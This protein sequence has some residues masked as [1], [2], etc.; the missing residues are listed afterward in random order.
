MSL[1][2]T[3]SN[4]VLNKILN[5]LKSRS[6]E[7]KYKAANDLKEHVISVSREISGE[8]FT[9]FINDVNRRIFA[10]I[11]SN[12]NDEKIGGIL[13]IDS[14]IDFDGEENTT[15]ITRFANYLRFVLPGNDLQTMVLASKALGRLALSGGTL[16]PEFVEFEVKRA[17]EW[18]QGDRHESKRYAA[19]LVLK[20]LAQNA[21]ILIYSYVTQ[22]LNLIW[23]VLKDPKVVIREGAANALSVCL[24]LIQQRENNK[25][26]ELYKS[27]LDEA[28][29]G[30]KFG[31]SDTVHGCLLVIRELLLHT[32]NFMN[33]YYEDITDI[34][35][36]N[37]D[38]KDNLIRRTVI[39]LMS[40]LASFDPQTFVDNYLKNCMD[41]LLNQLKKDRDRSIA[42]TSIGK[43]A[44]AV[45]SNIGPYLDSIT[46]NIR[47]VLT[48]KSRSRLG[49][50]V[51]IFQCISMLATAVGQALTKHMHELLDI[52]LAQ[53]LSEALIQALSDLAH[54]IPPLL[55]AIQDRLLNVLSIILS[56][57]PYHHPNSLKQNNL[58][59]SQIQLQTTDGHDTD[60]IILALKTLGTFNFSGHMLNEFVREYIVRY[61]EDDNAEVRKS[62]AITCCH[63]LV[64]DPV[65]YQ[66]SNNSMLIVGEVLEKL[67]TVGITDSDPQIRKTV[68][69]SLDER[70]DH[71]LAQAENIRTLFLALNDEVFEIREV[72]I[73][74]IGR[75]IVHN[76]AYIMPSLRK[77]LIQLLSEIEYSGV[78]RN[79][80]E[81]ARLLS[82]LIKNSR[83]LI[84]P[85]VEPLLKVL[86]PK[87]KD[88]SP[89]VASESLKAIGELALIGEEMIPYLD[90]LFPMIIETLQ[91]QSNMTKRE[92]ALKT[93]GQLASNTGYIIEPYI[94]YPNLLNILIGI[95]KTEQNM[96]IRRQTLKVMGILGALDPYK[97]KMALRNP[98]ENISNVNNETPE[99]NLPLGLNP[100][101]E[102]YYPTVAI[103]ALMR[104]LRDPS[105]NV[106]HTAVVQAIIYIFKTLG[107]KCV[108]FLPQIMP[109]FLNMMRVCQVGNLE[110]YFQQLGILVTVVKQHIRNYL[111]E[112]YQL[113][114]EFWNFNSNI[115]LTIISLMESIAVALNCEFKAYLPQLLPQLLQIFETDTSE[116]RQLTIKVLKAFIVFGS[117]LEE[118]LHLVIPVIIKLFERID[119][120]LD[121]RREAIQTIG[122]LCKNVNF[123]DHA[124]R[125][126][127]PLVRVLPN[128]ELR[129]VAMDTLIKLVL[130]LNSDYAIF[131]P[132]VNKILIKNHIQHAE[133]DSLVTKL[134]KN[135]PLQRISDNGEDSMEF[136]VDDNLTAEIANKKLP[137]NQ[138]HL[139]KAWEASQ[140]S[141]KEDWMEWLRRLSVELLKESPSPA[142]RA[143]A[144]LASVYYPLSR[145]LFNAGF[146][147]C[148]G[149]LY[150]QFQDELV[151]SLETAL[152]SPNIPPELIQTLLN[153]AEFMEHDDKALPI[154]IKTLG[155]FA[156][157]CHTYAKALH[158]KEL[159]FI[160]EPKP[161]NIEALISINNQLQQPDSAIGIL[162]YAQENHDI[163][164]KESWYEKLQRWEDALAA[165][166]RKQE[167]DPL[168]FEATIG[169][170][171]CLHALGEW[172]A[173]SQLVKEK[174]NV[175]SDK[176]KIMA[177]LAA[178][179]AWGLSDYELMEEYI[180]AMKPDSPDGSFFR[181]ILTVNSNLFPQ[182]EQYI[183]KTRDLLDTELTALVGESYN[184]AY[185][186]VV[187]IQMLAELEEII[188][189]KKLFDQPD[190]QAIIR[191]TWMKRLKGCQKNIDIWHR[192][193]RIQALVI[194]PKENMEMWIKFANL[195]RKGGRLNTALKTL[196]TLSNNNSLD[197]NPMS[198]PPP[199]VYAYL[200]YL[201]ATPENRSHAFQ[202]MKIFTQNLVD[203]LEN[204]PYN[205]IPY[206]MESNNNLNGYQN[207]VK[208]KKLIARCYL[209]L[210]E[211][212]KAQT[213]E[214]T[215]E[216][217]P[218][219]LN[220]LHSAT[221][222]DSE[223]YKA[224]HSWA[225]TNFEVINYYEKASD[226]NVSAKDL[227]EYVKPSIFGFFKS[228][229]LSK[230]NSLQD[231]LRLITLWFKYGY[232]VEVNAAVSEGLNRVSID[233]WL[234]VIPQLIARI[235]TNHSHV[236]SLLQQLLTDVGKEHPQALIYSLT[237]ASKSPNIERQ[238]A[239]NAIMEK[240]MIHSATLV[241]QA[242]LV[243]Q[244]L[245]RVAILWHEMWHEGLEEA[246]RLYFGNH[247]IEGMFATLQPL[248]QMLEKGPET[249]REI[250]FNQGFGRDLSEALD[251]CR[252]YSKTKDIN[253]LNQAWDLYYNVFRKINKQLPQLTTL[254]L[255]YV[256]PKLLNARDLELAV[257]GQ[258]RS[259]EPIIR[260]QSFVPTLNIITSKQRP[261]RLSIKGSDGKE[262][263]YLLKGH[264]DLRQDERVM[265]LFGLINTLLADDPE[266][267]TRHM[268]IQRYPVIP[269]SPNSGLIGWVPHCDTL[270]AL[271]RDYRESK[272]TLLNI[273]HRLM[274]QMAPDYDNLTLLQKV[275]VFEYAADNTTG[276]DL[277][278]VLWIKSRNSEAWLDR[279]TN[280]TR[281]L[282]VMSMVGYIL[283]LGD[284]HPSNLM[285]DRFTGKVVHIDFGDCFEVAMHREKFPE[286]IPFR[287]TR[288]L[289]NAM[290]VS[291]I[292]EAFVYDPLINWRLITNPSPK[293]DNK[294]AQNKRSDDDNRNYNGN[295]KQRNENEILNN[296]EAD[297]VEYLNPRAVQIIN[298]IQNK[299]TGRDFKPN[300]VLDVRSQ[301]YKLIEQ[302]TSVENLCQCYIGW[303]A[304]W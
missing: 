264:E 84:K 96:D 47:E 193:L 89:G 254:E 156:A 206:H 109:A 3:P 302:A 41:Y 296:E 46:L 201:W 251:W 185:S 121:L 30:L 184:R 183:N 48:Q 252:K 298:R 191:K 283:G 134:L 16:T 256:S 159:E 85:Y 147:S 99:D 169:K 71:H 106:H 93:L 217:I 266:T 8:N 195:C 269:L 247:N 154:D 291:G 199:V 234:Q 213:D 171:R 14:L 119:A 126:I 155:G 230:S 146:V 52:M 158:Y 64:N 10:L 209:R 38:S 11:Q 176:Q 239:A 144:S 244:E 258:Y 197:G 278:K 276:Q 282:A 240:M 143:C 192:I 181:A 285:L 220:S 24:V 75:L 36:K 257:P 261:R 74:I 162:T 73:T 25:N 140:R 208:L 111:T 59:Q 232:N 29:K 108:S 189:Y 102:E 113:I 87:C 219:I 216:M 90:D 95:L 207:N 1:S 112:I 284:R 218:E 164:L 31:S 33:G 17:L 77:T 281:S 125:I 287:L 229:A 175:F 168:S 267:F 272:K 286:R 78:S 196:L 18:L 120:P 182:A 222:Y 161:S 271:I 58:I 188:S 136:N 13:A 174:W 165:Y 172:E 32:G 212:Q 275:E 205:E 259:G 250:S 20:E 57:Q 214:L 190:R 23:V 15:K 274:L 4:E 82:H 260:I 187:R 202:I 28:Q 103:N 148:W 141:T 153:L 231:T 170:M 304:F 62:A 149:E 117:N 92:V 7:T 43:I 177:P 139:K 225:L 72:T 152:T 63:L 6:E 279:R 21:P 39:S 210:G 137:V 293:V 303:C 301:V 50:E 79:K 294:Q 55:P 94:K 223:W 91:D 300:N 83:R 60:I 27:I 118:Y 35:I 194:S 123:S 110:F 68:L 67:L 249:M 66:T 104:I 127:H 132:M 200:K 54:Y 290:E 186:V 22:I 49:T 40:D 56:G 81:A 101:S 211:W 116:K 114:Q 246:S 221:Y 245:I 238:N 163:K 242:L 65:C 135:E 203:Q 277:Y 44:I 167:E 5:D 262:Y 115:Q 237:V 61:L 12:D 224:W 70:F 97:H 280:Y 100:S 86:I 124:S 243:S 128:P 122:S 133:Y 76:P 160:S 130:Q 51:Y 45:G 253:D 150:D 34:V 88:S 178:G 236:R 98:N 107:L 228:I 42:F 255:K 215:I 145:E 142:L 37:R 273:E 265:Q 166:E 248:H 235:Y 289:I 297:K 180:D 151:R 299:L 204:S 233:T 157:K 129:N 131:V 226:N 138:Q 53:G 80:E 263:Q 227:I 288:M 292:E 173:L 69:S 270:H 2:T 19:V 241:N 179:A 9:K 105:L 268:N 295:R 198:N 26:N